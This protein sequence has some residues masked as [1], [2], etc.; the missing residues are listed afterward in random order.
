MDKP[1]WAHIG[2]DGGEIDCGVSIGVKKTIDELY[3]AIERELAD[4]Y[5][6]IKLKIK[7]GWDIDVLAQVRERFP[8]TP[9]M[10]DAN[11]AYTLADAERLKE[12]DRFHLT[13]VEQPL[14]HDD[15]IDHIELQRMMATPI[16]LD[17][18]IHH[19]RHAE[20]AIQKRACGIINIKLSRV[21][22]YSEAILVHDVARMH[23]IPV[24]CGGMLE[25]GVGRAHN[26]ALST[27]ENF[28]L[29]GDVSASKRYFE[30]DI[31][32]PAV[33]VSS[34]GTIKP[35]EGPGIGYEVDLDYVDSLTVRKEE[36]RL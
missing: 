12:L 4:G 20:Q 22:G 17:E 8:D 32:A 34:R 14:S 3:D 5:Q 19:A 6:R 28:R 2:G 35:P 10:A 18:S 9:I 11:S 21:G 13:M 33:E 31:I 29:P 16:C 27:L 7:P 1:L 24:W 30:R 25:T 23:E 26:V 15:I 36:I